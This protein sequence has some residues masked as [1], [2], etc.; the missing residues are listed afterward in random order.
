MKDAISDVAAKGWEKGL[1]IS[2]DFCLRVG[3]GVSISGQFFVTFSS[4]H[5]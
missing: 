1:D 4:I 3:L 5:N 2:K